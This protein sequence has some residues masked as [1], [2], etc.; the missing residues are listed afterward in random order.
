M[1]GSFSRLPNSI[2]SPPFPSGSSSQATAT[3]SF[4]S[5]PASVPRA[6]CGW[7]VCRGGRTTNLTTELLTTAEERQRER[8][9]VCVY[10]R[11]RVVKKG[12][13]SPKLPPPTS[14]SPAQLSAPWPW[15]DRFDDRGL[16]FY[17]QL[18]KCPDPKVFMCSEV[19]K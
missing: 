15:C 17:N 3:S 4:R 6:Q 8:V 7:L 12:R 16:I 10:V 11:K 14:P 13:E 9:C 19:R 18:P 5:L 2:S 1:G